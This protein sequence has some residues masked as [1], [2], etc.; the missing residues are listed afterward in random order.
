MI[1]LPLLPK[2]L[3]VQARLDELEGDA[4]SAY[5]NQD[6][7]NYIRQGR[8]A[9]ATAQHSHMLDDPHWPEGQS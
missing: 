1:Y 6:G 8:V 4:T 9:D 3:A 2:Q 7:P 5:V